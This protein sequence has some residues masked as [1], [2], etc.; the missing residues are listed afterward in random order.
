V[1]NELEKMW[2]GAAMAYFKILSQNLP[3]RTEKSHRISKE[4]EYRCPDSNPVLPE[5]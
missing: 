3:G 4:E 2:K 1:C 5:Y